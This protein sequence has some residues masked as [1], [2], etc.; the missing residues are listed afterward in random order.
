MSGTAPS[1]RSVTVGSRHTA[2]SGPPVV[3][4]PLAPKRVCFYKSGDPQFSG[5]RAVVSGR[6]F[7]SFDALLD[8]LSKKVPL[9][10]GVRTITT[11]RG[12]HAVLSL[13]ELEDGKSYLCSD[14]RRVKPI[15]LEAARRRPL[16]WNSA[17]PASRG[18]RA[19]QPA[20]SRARRGSPAVVPMPKTLTVFRNGDPSTRHTVTL[21]GTSSLTFDTLLGHISE[22]LQVPVVKLF[23]PDG[24]RVDGLAALLLCSAVVA[25]SGHDPFRPDR[26]SP[27]KPP[28]TSQS[29]R[30]LGPDRLQSRPPYSPSPP[31]DTPSTFEGKSKLLS[32]KN[33]RNF[34]PS[35]E[36]LLANQISDSMSGSLVKPHS[37]CTVDTAGLAC[38][39]DTAGLPC[40]GD[41]DVSGAG[42]GALLPP[43]VDD[44]E[45]SC[46]IN[47]D[48]SMTVEMKVRLMIKEE[49]TIH[50]TT[51]LSR[52]STTCWPGEGPAPQ[53]P[54]D[55]RSPDSN[56]PIEDP[57][58][59]GGRGGTNVQ[60]P[61]PVAGARDPSEEGEDRDAVLADAEKP[62]IR[63]VQTPGPRALR[64][65]LPSAE[66]FLSDSEAL[67]DMV[68]ASHAHTERTAGSTVAEKHSSLTQQHSHRPTPKRRSAA[69]ANHRELRSAFRTSRS[70]EVLQIQNNGREVTESVLHVYE[71]QSCF[72]GYFGNAKIAGEHQSMSREVRSRTFSTD[73]APRSS[74][75]DNGRLHGGPSVTSE[76]PRCGESDRT[77]TSP[78]PS[79]EPAVP[80]YRIQNS[81]SSSTDNEARVTMESPS[82]CSLRDTDGSES[83]GLGR[84]QKKSSEKLKA[85]KKASPLS[86]IP[87]RTLAEG[88]KVD[89]RGVRHVK[90]ASDVAHSRDG[91][92]A[93]GGAEHEQ[94]QLRKIKEKKKGMRDSDDIS[95]SHT[96]LVNIKHQRE[97]AKELNLTEG[98]SIT[99]TKLNLSTFAKTDLLDI[100]PPLLVR[101]ML[102][103]QWSMNEERRGARETGEL[104]ESVSM[105]VLHSCPS[106]VTEYVGNWLEKMTPPDVASCIDDASVTESAERVQFQIGCDSCDES[107]A[108]SEMKSAPKEHSTSEH[109]TERLSSHPPTEGRFQLGPERELHMRK[110]TGVSKSD[111]CMKGP[112]VKMHKSAEA[113]IQ[114]GTEMPLASEVA[115]EPQIKPLLEQLC[116]S[117][118]SIN[119]ISQRGHTPCL[120]MSHGVPDFSSL[121]ASIF[122]SSSK[123]LIAFL[124]V[125]ALKEAVASLGRDLPP[126]KDWSVSEALQMMKALH[127][128]ASL[129][130][131]DE[132]QT[133][134][135]DLHRSASSELLQSW[136]SFQEL[137]S[138][139]DSQEDFGS[140]E[141][142]TLS[143]ESSHQEGYP[144][145][146]QELMKELDI[147]SDLQRELSGLVMG[148]MMND[149]DR[150]EAPMEK[151]EEASS[152]FES[153][154]KED[155]LV[156]SVQGIGDSDFAQSVAED[157]VTDSVRSLAE[158]VHDCTQSDLEKEINSSEE[159]IYEEKDNDSATPVQEREADKLE[160]SALVEEDDSQA[161][162]GKS[163]NDH[164][165]FLRGNHI[166]GSVSEEYKSTEDDITRNYA[167]SIRVDADTEK[168]KHSTLEE[169]GYLEERG[170]H[171]GEPV[172]SVGQEKESSY[173]QMEAC[174]LQMGT[175]SEAFQL[176]SPVQSKKGESAVGDSEDSVR[177]AK[178]QT[179]SEEHEDPNSATISHSVEIPEALLEYVRSVLMS[180]SLVFIHDSRGHVR[181]ESERPCD[182]SVKGVPQY[183]QKQLPSPSMSDLSDYR[184]TS[185]SDRCL[186][187]PSVELTSES[188]GE[189]SGVR[190]ITQGFVDR[191]EGGNDTNL[192]EVEEYQASSLSSYPDGRT[193]ETGGASRGQSPEHATP[194]MDD[195]I[196]DGVLIDKGKWLLKENHLI[197]KSPPVPSGMYGNV[198]TTS[199]DTTQDD[200]SEDVPC[201]IQPGSH[202]SPMAV[203]SSSELEEL[204]GPA[205]PKCSYFNMSHGSDSEPFRD[206]LSDG[207]GRS[208]SGH[209]SGNG[210]A[211]QTK[212][213]PGVS[214]S[215]EHRQT[216]AKKCGSLSSF[217]SVEFKM[218]DNKVH[219]QARPSGGGPV[220]SQ[221]GG[222]SNIASQTL[223]EQDSLEKLHLVCGQH[224]PI[225]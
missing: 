149:V 69:A 75:N 218:A 96:L 206:E 144:Y 100:Q 86:P 102:V 29:A 80:S 165:L 134:L 193:E 166:D 116:S 1:Q 171:T 199:A 118:Q 87:G 162:Q 217:A 106:A 31:G 66:S 84:G 13:D 161:T 26:Y 95:K 57:D 90:S 59:D 127:K 219:P 204:A 93:E 22:L 14:R 131:T 19:S 89:L 51:T 163:M 148:E 152:S 159:S 2:A 121:V 61:M 224:C 30:H 137:G 24:R 139:A 12:T 4:D 215:H 72:D 210:K 128:L 153:A 79:P 64:K 65:R 112:K 203:L 143:E 209:R 17:L 105:P 82:E 55:E 33:S 97:S 54:T 125:L 83:H 94:R 147:S 10:F 99:E 202:R 156:E 145:G 91:V 109:D 208:L 196:S 142:P 168:C 172:I 133:G 43:D 184:E 44:I 180:S 15:D 126:A 8:G 63:R 123:M 179:G 225:L 130:N 177:M 117:I 223:Q 141:H 122:G 85:R 194:R 49:E 74:G 104:S 119:Q 120:A 48:G 132:L 76:P 213:E 67:E 78:K 186:S 58:V 7:K 164:A 195:A 35:S 101:K 150:N 146:F 53:E 124:S 154:T 88:L 176:S 178:L 81:P 135:S 39:G 110:S 207:S 201:C 182:G 107:E 189:G 140:S 173:R 222:A 160:E 205:M 41:W 40:A 187:Q 155:Y 68:G 62:R 46:R 198:E 214:P 183:G 103:K 113:L 32:R 170:S 136:R 169:A 52:S 47:Q 98:T 28:R 5:F 3:P 42:S 34:S 190:P 212:T 27:H 129:E 221:P 167:P 6:T 45:K 151:S 188:E 23:S 70:A 73:T 21:Q 114:S 216:R 191:S 192:E 38:A 108:K 60:L 18:R 181:V 50:W 25:S 200:V 37:G 92:R 56:N 111:V 71:Q 175:V 197:R 11:P 115:Q 174:F 157:E 20:G 77:P 185:E 138:L 36:T 158:E 9:P 220:E 16:P 211:T